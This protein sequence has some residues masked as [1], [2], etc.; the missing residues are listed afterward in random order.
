M[1]R[2]AKDERRESHS[3]VL[4]HVEELRAKEECYVVAAYPDE[5]FVTGAVQRLIL[6]PIDLERDERQWTLRPADRVLS[7]FLGSEER[8]H[9]FEPITLLACTVMLYNAE[10]TVRVLTDPAFLLVIATMIAWT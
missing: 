4:C 2:S 5:D 8:K 1:V 6:V 7:E 10:A 9:T 3:P